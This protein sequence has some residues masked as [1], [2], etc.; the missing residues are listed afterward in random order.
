[1]RN[2]SETCFET[3]AEVA[4]DVETYPADNK[5]NSGISCTV[6]KKRLTL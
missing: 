5:K 3:M 2:P 6:T 4:G 1:M